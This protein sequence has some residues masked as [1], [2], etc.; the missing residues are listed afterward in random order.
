MYRNPHQEG[1]PSRRSPSG[2]STRPAL[3]E[4]DS[5]VGIISEDQRGSVFLILRI[6]DRTIHLF[7]TDPL[8]ETCTQLA[9][10]PYFD[11][12]DRTSYPKEIERCVRVQ[13]T[14]D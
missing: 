7:R 2:D 1:S 11:E 14:S 12:L 13:E 5:V 8:W 4:T 10:P 3:P 6:G 9:F